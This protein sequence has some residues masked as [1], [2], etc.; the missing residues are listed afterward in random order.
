M[1]W[2]RVVRPTK[3][4]MIGPMVN[5]SQF[6]RTTRARIGSVCSAWRVRVVVTT[7]LMIM[8]AAYI[9]CFVDRDIPN[10][11]WVPMTQGSSIGN[12]SLEPGGDGIEYVKWQRHRGRVRFGSEMMD[13]G[14]IRV[15][16]VE[17]RG[18]MGIAVGH[19]RKLLGLGPPPPHTWTLDQSQRSAWHEGQ[20]WYAYR[21][22]DE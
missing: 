6:V 22:H 4:T 21:L 14:Q 7:C 13:P 11:V 16:A 19:I 17:E 8:F 12:P 3:W 9:V 10:V 18:T 2:F 20:P 1:V 5:Y 15:W